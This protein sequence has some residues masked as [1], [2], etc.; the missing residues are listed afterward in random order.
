[1]YEH[2]CNIKYFTWTQKKSQELF[3]I[4]SEKIVEPQ[5]KYQKNEDMH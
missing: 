2:A 5:K 4:F 3:A 1:M